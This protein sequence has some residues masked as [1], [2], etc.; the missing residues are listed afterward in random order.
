MPVIGFIGKQGSG[1]TLS[2]V[3]EVLIDSLK[4]MVV[5]SNIDL[6]GIEYKPLKLDWF[7][8]YLLKGAELNDVVVIIDELQL[9]ADSRSHKDKKNKVL[10][11]FS[12][13]TRKRNVKLYI[14]TQY[15]QNIDKRLRTCL[16]DDTIV[17]CK[18]IKNKKKELIAVI[19]TILRDGKTKK[20]TLRNP[21]KFFKYYRTGQV[22]EIV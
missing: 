9:Y 14:T 12:L 16:M 7:Y 8:G 10:G 13:Q 4:G 18:G 2:L 21:K 11:Y 17:M 5:Y 3:R 6:I 1:K 22:M 20:R 15:I 19:Q